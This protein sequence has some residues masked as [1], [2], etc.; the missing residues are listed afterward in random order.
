[1]Y[2]KWRK[3]YFYVSQLVIHACVTAG[4]TGR[5]YS[6]FFIS[7]LNQYLT[8]I[9]L[10]IL[11]I[12]LLFLFQAAALAALRLAKPLVASLQNASA[13]AESYLAR[14]GLRPRS[15]GLCPCRA[16]LGS[17]HSPPWGSGR[18]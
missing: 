11:C 7:Q 12:S 1:M 15:K 8:N 17:P 16:A 9:I 4:D 2:H 14:S 3:M 5:L 18:G 6:S 10:L 13:G